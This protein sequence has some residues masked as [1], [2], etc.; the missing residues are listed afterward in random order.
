MMAE[1]I[2]YVV[3]CACGGQIEPVTYIDDSRPVGSAVTVTAPDPAMKQIISAI[4]YHPEVEN[5]RA[6]DAYVAGKWGDRAVSET[7]WDWD[8]DDMH[9]GWVI[10]C[11]R[12][13]DQAQ[14]SRATLDGIADRLALSVTRGDLVSVPAPDPA[15]SADPVDGWEDGMLT[16]AVW[17]QRYLI[18]LGV[19]IREA[20]SRC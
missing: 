18:Q 4:G 13:Q 7:V 14:M 5:W 16:E 6:P 17:R 2:R 20:Q 10:R 1:P 9:T 12:C 11:D 8:D 19:L 3:V 15:E